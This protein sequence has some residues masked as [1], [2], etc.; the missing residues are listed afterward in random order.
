MVG[1]TAILA[2]D[3]VMTKKGAMIDVQV[4][5]L[6]THSDVMQLIK[7]KVNAIQIPHE[8]PKI[9]LHESKI[10]EVELKETN[11]YALKLRRNLKEY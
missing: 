8:P 11:G 6:N 3:T 2:N 7:E 10:H 4:A 1:I 9:S 5:F